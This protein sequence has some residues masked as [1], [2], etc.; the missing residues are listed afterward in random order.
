MW[1]KGVSFTS[2]QCALVYLV[3]A[4]GTRTTTDSFSDLSQDLSLSV[5]Y[6]ESRHGAPYIQEAKTILDESQYWLSDEGIENWIINNVRV[7]Q[8]PDGLVSGTEQQ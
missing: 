4:A 3:D 1:Y 5:Y 2:D 8:T 6:N 7:S